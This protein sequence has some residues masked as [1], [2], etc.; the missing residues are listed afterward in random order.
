MS[1]ANDNPAEGAGPSYQFTTTHWSVVVSAGQKDSQEALAALDRLCRTYWHP[2]FVYV[3]RR[4]HSE[5][6]AKDLTQAFFTQ[7][8]AKH[9][10]ADA[11][12][13]RGRFRT[14]LLT[15]LSHFLANERNRE[16]AQKRGGGFEFISLDYARE[17]GERSIDPGHEAT[18]EKIYEQRWAEAVLTRVLERLRHEF[19]GTSVKRFDLLKP[20]LT[21]EKGASSYSNAARDLG[22]SEQAVKSAVHRLRQR[23]RVLMREEIAHTLNAATSK[24]VDEEI[25]YLI[26]VLE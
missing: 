19:D 6:E 14:F 23:W 13:E 18:P 2:L 20:F 12:R 1:R 5:E 21:E 9:Y 4:G 16:Q 7:L 17:H 11:D 24:E 25:R 26:G 3:R 15:S 10:L 8:L 22:M